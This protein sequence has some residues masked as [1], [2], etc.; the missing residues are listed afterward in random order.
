MNNPQMVPKRLQGCQDV[1]PSHRMM[2]CQ[3][4]TDASQVIVGDNT[5]MVQHPNL[6]NNISNQPLQ[7]NQQ[8]HISSSMGPVN[9]HSQQIIDPNGQ[10]VSVQSPIN[11]HN[12]QI[13]HPNSTGVVIQGHN[14]IENQQP[15]QQRIFVNGQPNEPSG[16]GRPNIQMIPVSISSQQNIVNPQNQA[17]QQRLPH[18]QQH[19]QFYNG[20]P[21]F[22]QGQQFDSS[23]NVRPFNPVM[24]GF[25]PQSVPNQHNN[26][27]MQIQHQQKMQWQNR[28]PPVQHQQQQIQVP[29]QINQQVPIG[30]PSPQSSQPN[31]YERVPPLHQHTPSPTMW[32]ED[33]KRK[34]VKL[35]KVVKNRPYV[36]EVV[37]PNNP[38]C[39]NVDVRQ[40]PGENRAV[41]INQMPHS[42]QSAPSPS[43]MEDP[44][45]YLAQQTALLNS[46]INRQTGETEVLNLDSCTCYLLK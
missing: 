32:P 22:Q 36:M 5:V 14:V 8:I 24:N 34:K 31:V 18:P 42:N 11:S 45:G 38:P 19:I 25:R 43:F 4:Q 15:H 1:V 26:H 27:M 44:S 16:P 23:K 3:D 2:R 35:G 37:Q 21:Q 40:I 9:I 13:S 17:I 41:I 39:P 20:Q 33:V 46:T 10:I 29:Q 28:I 7:Q 6:S 30:H 12:N